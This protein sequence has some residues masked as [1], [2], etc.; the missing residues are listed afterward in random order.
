MKS[1]NLFF[2][3]LAMAMMLLCFYMMFQSLPNDQLMFTTLCF[4][5]WGIVGTVAV[6]NIDAK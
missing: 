5:C 4:V 1:L 6:V 3:F 2:A